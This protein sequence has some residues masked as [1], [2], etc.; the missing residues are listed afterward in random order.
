VLFLNVNALDLANVKKLAT[1]LKLD[2]TQFNTCVDGGKY[3]AAVTKDAAE[4]ADAGVSGTPAFFINGRP[5]S[6]ALPFAT[7]QELIEEALA[8]Q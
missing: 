4:G 1:D 3:A 6:G 5:A 2:M 8:A 7:F